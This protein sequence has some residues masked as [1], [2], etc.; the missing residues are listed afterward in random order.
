MRT[1]SSFRIRP[2]AEKPREKLKL[3][4]GALLSEAELLAII[5]R[6]GA[7]GVS[8]LELAEKMLDFFGGLSGVLN[9]TLEEL[10]S[11]EG[12]GLAKACQIRAMGE[13]FRR[14]QRS[15]LG[16]E[17][18]ISSPF[19]AY[20]VLKG[21]FSQEREEVYVLLLDAKCRLIGV[22]KVGQGTLTEAPFYPREVIAAALKANAPRMI[23]SHNHLSGD[24]SPSDEDRILTEKISK[25]ASEMGMRLDDHIIIGK[26]RFYSFSRRGV[27]EEG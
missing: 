7:A 12:I 27:L 25:L 1:R 26:K 13:I 16:L 21:F 20:K 17:T 8:V 10:Q 19:E 6:T 24:P 22:R 5:L 2:E 15:H 4:G 18:R 11:I 23:V 3:Y 14:V 9:A